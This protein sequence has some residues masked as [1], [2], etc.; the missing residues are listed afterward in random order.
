MLSGIRKR[1]YEWKDKKEYERH[2]PKSEKVKNKRKMDDRVKKMLVLLICIILLI[3]VVI[4]VIAL[5]KSSDSDLTDEVKTTI[6]TIEMTTVADE[7]EV[8]TEMETEEST[9]I[10]TTKATATE[11]STAVKKKRK[12]KKQA[13]YPVWQ[14]PEVTVKHSDIQVIPETRAQETRKTERPT[15]KK[16]K[17]IN[18][19]VPAQRQDTSELG[20]DATQLIINTVEN[21]IAG[22][23]ND[24]M[25]NLAIYMAANNKSNAQSTINRLCENTTIKVTSRTATATARSSAL[26]DVLIAA[27]KLADS[28][29]GNGHKYGVGIKVTYINCKFKVRAV[30]AIQT[31]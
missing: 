27:E 28:L 26:D 24:N 5:K 6:E 25:R 19:T 22:N 18:N 13:T 31:N 9:V 4:V 10:V 2:V 14:E 20:Y 21:A 30:V 8:T 29:R 12:K 1:Y 11:T 15:R 17:P 7:T 23:R 16:A 3:I